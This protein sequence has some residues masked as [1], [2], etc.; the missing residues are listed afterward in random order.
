MPILLQQSTEMILPVGMDEAYIFLQK[1]VT[2]WRN[3]GEF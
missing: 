1:G 3:D 2:E